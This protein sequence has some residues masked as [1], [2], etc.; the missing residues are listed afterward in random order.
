MA[1]TP[2]FIT[3][4]GRVVG[5]IGGGKLAEGELEALVEGAGAGRSAREAG[6]AGN[7]RGHGT[8]RTGEI[9]AGEN[10]SAA[11]AEAGGIT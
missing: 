3:V 10:G 8:A 1:G 6:V 7:A 11:G 2:A 4:E 5:A 9:G